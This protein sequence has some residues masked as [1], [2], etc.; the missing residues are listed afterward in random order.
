MRE[1]QVDTELETTP[2]VI[3]N[4]PEPAPARK[5]KVE[6]KPAEAED[7]DEEK[8]DKATGRKTA[9]MSP[10]LLKLK[11]AADLEIRHWLDAISGEAP[12]RV[13]IIRREPKTFTDPE[14]GET[15]KT[16]GLVQTYDRTIDEIEVQ[17]RHGG[18]TYQFNVKTKN[19]AGRWDYFAA[20]TIEIAGD[21]KLNDVPRARKP[22]QQPIVMP[23]ARDPSEGK[24]VEKMF[25]AMIRERAEE[26]NRPVAPT[27]PSLTDLA[28]LMRP[29][30]LQIENLTRLLAAKDAELAAARATPADPFR[31]RM[32]TTLMD[33]ESARITALRT[34]H[35]SEVRQLKEGF[36]QQEQ[37]LREQFARD[38][39]RVE[40]MHD[41]EITMIKA[42]NDQAIAMG[43]HATNVQKTVLERELA[44]QDKQIAKLDAELVALRAKKDQTIKEKVDELQAIK[45]LVGDEEGEEESKLTQVISAIGNIPAVAKL[46]ERA[47]GGLPAEQQQQAQQ[48]RKNRLVR[49]R[50][51]GE[52][53]M[54]TPKGLVP[55][56][57]K[58]QAVTKTDG[59]QVEIP[60]MDEE[61]VKQAVSFMTSAFQSGTDPKTFADTARPM[62]PPPVMG[63]IRTLGVT[64]FLIKVAKL[65]GTSPLMTQGG[66]NWAKTVAKHLLG[67]TDDLP[68]AG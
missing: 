56:K 68:A 16:D 25:D 2:A 22:E 13:S 48:P 54:E 30:E 52:I 26:R 8:E 17:Q 32:L 67:D 29:L 24:V 33:N 9:S 7:E 59:E 41:R 44:S 35:E 65:D 28:V 50:S 34:N 38:L 11:T 58:P 27:G 64:D 3:V 15:K 66:R 63:A 43:T 39:D 6:T 55:M 37:R 61:A 36:A 1:V 18:G 46:A 60:A 49:D 21:P 62:V 12:L 4:A 10:T 47:A 45:D 14:T 31:D 5:A 51:T 42:A 20:R 23:P 19:A 57:K 40:R 53:M